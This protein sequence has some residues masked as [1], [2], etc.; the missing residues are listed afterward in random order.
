MNKVLTTPL[1][2][3]TY[4]GHDREGR[5]AANEVKPHGRRHLG[6]RRCRWKSPNPMPEY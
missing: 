3:K 5:K 1:A 2:G 4:D 6:M